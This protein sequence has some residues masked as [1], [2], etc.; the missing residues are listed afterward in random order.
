[1]VNENICNISFVLL[2]LVVM[3]IFIFFVL[4]NNIIWLV[5]YLKCFLIYMMKL[6]GVSWGFICCLFLKRNIWSG[7]LV[8]FIVDM[9]LMGVVYWLVFYEFELI[10]VIMFEVML[11]VLGVVLVFGVV[12]IFLCVYF[13]INKYLRMK[14]SMLYYV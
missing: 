13:F 9:I 5:I 14:V 12:I 6:V 1:M 7:V 11:L 10:W 3:L 8:V 4:I 2:V